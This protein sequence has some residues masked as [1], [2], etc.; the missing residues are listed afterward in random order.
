MPYQAKQEN[1]KSTVSSVNQTSED[2]ARGGISFSPPILRIYAD[3]IG[4]SS[5]G[6]EV[7]NACQ[8]GSTTVNTVSGIMQLQRNRSHSGNAN[9]LDYAGSLQSY[10]EGMLERHPD[11]YSPI[12]MRI[13]A[14]GI[15]AMFDELSGLISQMAQVEGEVP[16]SISNRLMQISSIVHNAETPERNQSGRT[17]EGPSEEPEA[18]VGSYP[19]YFGAASIDAMER[20][21][22]QAESWRWVSR[23]TVIATLISI[24]GAH[25]GRN[26]RQ[27]IG[28]A[29]GAIGQGNLDF[30]NQAQA[31]SSMPAIARR[32]IID[33]ATLTYAAERLNPRERQFWQQLIVNLGGTV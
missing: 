23:F 11:R 17:E 2:E 13:E 8:K 19:P 31:L 7:S 28:S 10:I 33:I 27:S 1:Q 32:S 20:I 18:R 6:Q 14:Q 16:Q 4:E 5:S 3:P 22:A 25:A 30:E 15:P 24:G 26:A 29:A 21:E 9:W 12:R